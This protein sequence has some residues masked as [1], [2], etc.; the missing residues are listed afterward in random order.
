MCSSE[1]WCSCQKPAGLAG[2][3]YQTGG[4]KPPLQEEKMNKCWAYQAISGSRS[5]WV[6]CV[7]RAEH[8]SRFCARH[9]RAVEGA[10]LG[11][12]MHA[13]P[14]DATVLFFEDST[15][16]RRRRGKQRR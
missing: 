1:T 15:S 6:P 5:A 9:G 4:V 3:Q 7:R 8:G 13:E 14:V 2:N 12:L 16:R 10:V 11:A